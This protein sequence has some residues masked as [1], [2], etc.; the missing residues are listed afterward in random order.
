MELKKKITPEG[1]GY[2][3]VVEATVALKDYL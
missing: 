3:Y 2:D 1:E